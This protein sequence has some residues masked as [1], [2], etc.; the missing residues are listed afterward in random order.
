MVA[1]LLIANT[2]A[3]VLSI[4]L[5]RQLWKAQAELRQARADTNTVGACLHHHGIEHV[6]MFMAGVR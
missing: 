4:Q 6:L 1:L 3:A 5:H 2:L